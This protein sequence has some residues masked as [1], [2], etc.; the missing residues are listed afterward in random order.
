MHIQRRL[1]AR[2]PQIEL[3]FQTAHSGGNQSSLRAL[4]PQSGRFLFQPGIP[5]T[6]S[7]DDKSRQ[8]SSGQLPGQ[9]VHGFSQSSFSALGFQQSLPLLK[10][11][12][13]LRCSR[14]LLLLVL[15]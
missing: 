11:R 13:T 1:H 6:V 14:R 10:S 4:S 2:N 15:Q 8:C 5:A 3:R 7:D 12:S 9:L